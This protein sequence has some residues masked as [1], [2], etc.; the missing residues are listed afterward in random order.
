MGIMFVGGDESIL[1][2]DN[3]DL[4]NSVHILKTIELY[5]LERLAV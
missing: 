5:T 1:K 3:S 2:L 4:Q